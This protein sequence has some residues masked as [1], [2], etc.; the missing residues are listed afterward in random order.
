[1]GIV[2]RNDVW[3]C[4]ICQKEWL[5]R[6]RENGVKIVP[7]MCSS[8]E[9]PSRRLWNSR[10]E[11][12]KLGATVVKVRSGTNKNA[13]YA[14]HWRAFRDKHK[15]TQKEVAHLLGVAERTVQYI[16]AGQT[17]P[18][19]ETQAKFRALMARQIERKNA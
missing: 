15:V 14:T 12:A 11:Q 16:E 19:P 9:C 1:M 5:P 6:F 2:T 4:D 7:K 18:T 3:R 10:P 13:P 17:M 8:A